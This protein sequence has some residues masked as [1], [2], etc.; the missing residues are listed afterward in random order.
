MQRKECYV[1]VNADAFEVMGVYLTFKDVYDHAY[2]YL[3]HAYEGAYRDRLLKE[4]EAQK[5]DNHICIDEILWCEKS[6][7]IYEKF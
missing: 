2:D 7:L 4:L 6:V 1:L 3:S 5:N